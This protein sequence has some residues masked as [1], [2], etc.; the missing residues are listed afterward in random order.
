[1]HPD[2]R[3]IQLPLIDPPANQ[4]TADHWRRIAHDLEDTVTSLCIQ[5]T[6]TLQEMKD[7]AAGYFAG[8]LLAYLSGGITFS[9]AI[10]VLR[11]VRS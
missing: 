6:A 2:S 8:L 3:V 5:H 9:V 1:M 4:V 7:R 11:W 10:A